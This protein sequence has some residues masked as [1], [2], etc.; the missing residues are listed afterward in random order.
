MAE[1]N[2]NEIISIIKEKLKGRN[3]SELTDKFAAEFQVE[4]AGTFYVEIKDG[5]INIE[6]YEYN[7]R[8]V[9]I[10]TSADNLKAIVDGKLGIEKALLTRKVVV[11]GNL[12]KAMLI[13]KLFKKGV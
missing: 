9:L 8:D 13:K 10:Q 5:K 6:P 7:D 2:V 11:S 3:F 12:Q 4:N 1:N